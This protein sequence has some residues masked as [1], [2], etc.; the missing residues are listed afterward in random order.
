MLLDDGEV[1]Q[2]FSSIRQMMELFENKAMLLDLLSKNCFPEPQFS[3][4]EYQEIRNA[5]QDFGIIGEHF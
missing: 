4:P 2:I 1:A 3:S 5:A